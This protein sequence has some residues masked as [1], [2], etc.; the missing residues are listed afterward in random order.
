MGNFGGVLIIKFDWK[1]SALVYDSLFQSMS[2]SAYLPYGIISYGYWWNDIMYPEVWMR[3]DL[4]HSVRDRD[5]ERVFYE[6]ENYFS[7]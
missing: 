7:R 3:N 1:E 6:W 5:A 2:K 4:S